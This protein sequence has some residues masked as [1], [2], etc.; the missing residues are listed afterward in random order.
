MFA[1][2]TAGLEWFNISKWSHLIFSPQNWPCST[3]WGQCLA[4]PPCGQL[5]SSRKLSWPPELP[6]PW[7]LQ[8]RFVSLSWNKYC[9]KKKVL[10]AYKEGGEESTLRICAQ[11]G[12]IISAGHS[13]SQQQE[14]FQR[15]PPVATG[16][17]VWR[18]L[19]WILQQVGYFIM[20]LFYTNL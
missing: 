18:S 6:R 17:G 2:E 20:V 19:C 15:R 8:P 13:G 7:S 4:W 1:S 9:I 14:F 11:L 3:W 16:S 10:G 12:E 5:P